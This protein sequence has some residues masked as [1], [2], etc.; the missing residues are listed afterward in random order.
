MGFALQQPPL[1]V[2]VL[3]TFL[4]LGIAAPYLILAASPKLIKKLPRP[5]A[6]ME[7][8]KKILAFPIFMAAAYFLNTFGALAGRS[9]MSWLLFALIVAAL[10]L[11]ILSHWASPYKS[12]KSRFFGTITALA[13]FGWSVWLSASAIRDRVVESS[14]DKEWLPW[15]PELISKL[16]DEGRT[17]FVDFT[18]P[19]CLTCQANERIVFHSP[20]SEQVY[21]Q[22]KEKNVALVLANDLGRD[23]RMFATAKAVGREGYPVNLVYPGKKK[24]L[25]LREA[26]TQDHVI[27]AL[28]EAEKRK[29]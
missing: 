19:G 17:I 23:P 1:G 15:S 16:R 25:L 5:G 6:W 9:S 8:F 21:A 2:F 24:P 29:K 7:T 12:G 14:A 11:Y 22:L 10:G 26:L 4:G 27:R 18:T 13:L 28:E 20:G 3:F